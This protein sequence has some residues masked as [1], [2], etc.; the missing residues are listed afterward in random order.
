MGATSLWGPQ[1]WWIINCFFFLRFSPTCFLPPPFLSEPQLLSPTP[2]LQGFWLGSGV[3]GPALTVK[4]FVFGALSGKPRQDRRCDRGLHA[5]QQHFCQVR[6]PE[7]PVLRMLTAGPLSPPTQGLALPWDWRMRTEETRGAEDRVRSSQKGESP[8]PQLWGRGPWTEGSIQQR[9]RSYLGLQW[10]GV[11]CG[12]QALHGHPIQL[13]SWGHFPLP[14]C[15]LFTPKGSEG[16]TR[17]CWNTS[18]CS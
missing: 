7:C 6:E 11:S 12:R 14:N 18:G 10:W 13:A 16:I 17:K 2:F 1:V 5:L 15:L 9:P 8:C 4:A 3:G